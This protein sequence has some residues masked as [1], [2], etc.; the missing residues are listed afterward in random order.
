MNCHPEAAQRRKDPTFTVGSL[1]FAQDDSEKSVRFFHLGRAPRV[2]AQDDTKGVR[3]SRSSASSVEALSEPPPR[4]SAHSY[5]PDGSRE[6]GLGGRGY[7]TVPKALRTIV[8]AFILAHE[9]LA[10]P[11]GDFG[12]I[13][14]LTTT[15][16]RKSAGHPDVCGG[17]RLALRGAP[18]ALA[19]SLSEWVGHSV[20]C[21]MTT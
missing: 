5:M 4:T 7:S 10:P 16:H 3:F 13:P 17:H 20:K 1:R 21:V 8:H 12:D 9:V 18:D 2:P 15:T 19:R 11:R 6:T 14:E